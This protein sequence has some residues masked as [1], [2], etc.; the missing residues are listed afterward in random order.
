MRCRPLL[1]SDIPILRKMAADSGF[2]YPELDD[3]LIESVI[4]VVD[5]SDVPIMACAAKRFIEGYLY[6]H[7]GTPPAVKLRA[8]ILLHQDMAIALRNIGYT[9][10]SVQVD[11]S[12]ADKFGRRLERTFGWVRNYWKT[13]T[14]RF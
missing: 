9:E 4:V 8:L 1:E 2:P 5:S 7:P 3:P 10:L 12:I 14:I 13:W 6:L 11:E